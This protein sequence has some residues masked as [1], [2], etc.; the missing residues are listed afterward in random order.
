MKYQPRKIQGTRLR[1]SLA[2]T[3]LIFLQSWILTAQTLPSPNKLTTI[4]L[5]MELKPP[6]VTEKPSEPYSQLPFSWRGE[7]VSQEGA[8]WTLSKGVIQTDEMLMMADLLIY[9]ASNGMMKA[10]GRIKITVQGLDF[11]SER[12]DFNWQ[13]RSGTA[14]IVKLD[15]QPTW[16]I[17]ADR[18]SFTKFRQW[19]FKTVTVTPCSEIEPGW[20]AS[21]SELDLD[22]DNYAQLWNLR[23]SIGGIPAPIYLPYLI[24]PS[25]TERTSGFLPPTLGTS[26]ALGTKLGLQYYQVLGDS[27][28]ATINPTWFS[29]E[30]VLWGTEFRWFLKDNHKG[31][32]SGEIIHS[33]SLNKTRYRFNLSESYK[34]TSGWSFYLRSNESSDNLMGIDYGSSVGS[35]TG[36]SHASNFLLEKNYQWGRVLMEAFS[37]RAFIQSTL[38]GDRVYNSEFP[39]SFYKRLLPELSLQSNPI[40]LSSI[41]MDFR[42]SLGS[43][44]YSARN[45]DQ[46]QPIDSTWQR[47][48]LALHAYGSLF[49]IGPSQW[50]FEV[51]GRGTYYTHS[52]AQPVFDLS[53]IYSTTFNGTVSQDNPF[54]VISKEQTR[55]LFSGKIEARLPQYG[56]I[57]ESSNRNPQG[58]SYKHILEPYLSFLNNSQYGELS[59]TPRFDAVDSFP[60]LDGSPI[61]EKSIALGIN[62]YLLFKPSGDSFFLNQ[63]KMDLSAKYHF[64]PIYLY[65]GTYQQGW[66]SLDGLLSYQ[67]NQRFRLS[68]RNSSSFSNRGSDRQ[69]VIDFMQDDAS[70]IGLSYYRSEMS[71]SNNPQHGIQ[72]AGLQRLFNDKFRL[73]YKVNY[74]LPESAANYT[75]GINYGEIGIAYIEPCRAYIFKFSKVPVSLIGMN[76]KKDNR[77]DL[78]ISLRGLGDIF[79]FRR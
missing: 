67:P 13:N 52:Y 75:P 18:V 74:T 43:Y 63:L 40:K 79:D 41:F 4:P 25:R 45:L 62:Q 55:T 49:D 24:Y 70:F 64:N 3:L 11:Y 1:S 15:L 48:D 58:A 47:S 68:L 44:N 37:N 39:S 69:A 30:G 57:Y 53:S 78:I 54:D 35:I 21:M 22:L 76:I 61:G 50:S 34:N 5:E 33:D 32:F 56:R 66:G 17:L 20:S 71:L 60:G 23:L 6:T 46:G 59:L 16:K 36:T 10:Q 31:N 7:G 19:N 77:I 29:K 26:S 9:N 2:H 14:D 12:I 28:D 72:L 73:E 8:I 42:L 65:D 51:L 27:A 38:E